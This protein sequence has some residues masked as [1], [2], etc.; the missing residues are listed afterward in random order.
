L[1]VS[2]CKKIFICH[3]SISFLQ[4]LA[5]VVLLQDAV[6]PVRRVPLSTH[7]SVLKTMP[8]P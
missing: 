3:K 2:V 4:C 5:K 1:E 7:V 8:G 6:L